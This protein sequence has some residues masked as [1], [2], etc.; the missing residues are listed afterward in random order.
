MNAS[1]KGR[2]LMLDERT[3]HVAVAVQAVLPPTDGGSK[4]TVVATT[5]SDENGEYEFTNLKPGQYQVRCYTLNGYVYYGEVEH[6]AV[7]T[8]RG[9]SLQLEHGKILKDVDFRIAPFKKG[10]WKNYTV[11]DGLADNAV[12]AIHQDSDGIMWVGTL[13]GVSRYDGNEFVNFT[14]ENG[15]ADHGVW[16]IHRNPDGV[17]VVWDMGW[18]VTV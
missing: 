8:R 11:L 17:G 6:T 16:S 14:T 12:V 2:L 9:A 18:F 5:L 15:L 7:E 13:G 10:T 4:P 3:L 1:I